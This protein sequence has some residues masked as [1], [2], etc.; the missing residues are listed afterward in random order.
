VPPPCAPAVCPRRVPIP[1]MPSGLLTDDD[2]AVVL[3]LVEHV[4]PLLRVKNNIKWLRR[5]IISYHNWHCFFTSPMFIK[6][7]I[8]KHDNHLAKIVNRKMRIVDVIRNNDVDYVNSRRRDS[9][10]L[11]Y[12]KHRLRS[13]PVDARPLADLIYHHI[14]CN[15]CELRDAMSSD[16][17]SMRA[18]FYF[19]L[20]MWYNH[21]KYITTSLPPSVTFYTFVDAAVLVVA[22]CPVPPTLQTL[23]TPNETSQHLNSC[24][25]RV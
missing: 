24:R 2:N 1:L 3:M 11:I 8:H 9:Y 13:P 12:I 7:S 19:V 17:P 4:F 14:R 18:H 22:S 6:G 10:N 21:M 16:N 25:P 15:V 20:G 5:T 23:Q